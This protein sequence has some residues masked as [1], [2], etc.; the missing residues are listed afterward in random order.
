[1]GHRHPIV[2]AIYDRC[3]AAQERAFLADLRR[4]LIARVGGTVIEVG[5]GTGLNLAHYRSAGM[6]R[7]H[8]LEPDPYMRRRAETR[9]AS[10]ELPIDF[11]EATAEDLPFPAASADTI[12]STLVFCSVD[13]P[14][15]AAKEVHRVLKPQGIFLFIEHVRSEEPWR[16]RLQDWIAPAWRRLAANC[17][18]DRRTLTTF[19]AAGFDVEEIR[20][21]PGGG[22]WGNPMVAG[23][24]RPRRR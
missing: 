9:A 17:H 12:V 4:D 10:S 5:A 24:G 20:R 19:G 7:L 14:F 16:A 13:D 23:I 18:V 15:R 11:G 1:V 21:V 2:A 6:R 8:L 22:P 3:C